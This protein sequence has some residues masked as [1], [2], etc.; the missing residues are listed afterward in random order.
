MKRA[1]SPL[2]NA[3]GYN[4]NN[5]NNNYNDDKY[6]KNDNNSNNNNNNN[7]NNNKVIVVVEV[8]VLIVADCFSN[9]NKRLPRNNIRSNRKANRGSH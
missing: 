4:I 9:R 3:K 2:I 1:D 7:N 8:V 5:H 6:D